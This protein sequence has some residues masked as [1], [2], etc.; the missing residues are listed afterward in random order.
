MVFFI[1]KVIQ[2]PI[3]WLLAMYPFPTFAYVLVFSALGFIH[4][5]AK[6]S[7]QFSYVISSL[8]IN[9]ENVNPSDVGHEELW[10][11]DPRTSILSTPR[12]I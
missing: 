2:R 11:K 12:E 8:V 6:L 1:S 3:L 9:K 10:R 5:N 4:Y 7:S